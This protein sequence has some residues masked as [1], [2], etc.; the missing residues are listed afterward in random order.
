[1]RLR[2]GTTKLGL[3]LA[4]LGAVLLLAG[5]PQFGRLLPERPGIGLPAPRL[6][7]MAAPALMAA[8]AAG[9]A[10]LVVAA[11]PRRRRKREPEAVRVVEQPPTPWWAY[12]LAAVMV[13]GLFLG[14]Y[15]L[16]LRAPGVHHQPPALVSDGLTTPAAA[17]PAPT[18]A[19]THPSGQSA[20]GEGLLSGGLA[21]AVLW[22]AGAALAGAMALPAVARLRHRRGLPG[23]GEAVR[24]PVPRNE[25]ASQPQ[26]AGMDAAEFDRLVE[27]VAGTADPRDAVIRAY[28]VLEAALAALNYR[29]PPARTAAEHVAASVPPPLRGN[30]D[31]FRLVEL[32]HEA[33][34][35]QRPTT[36]V[37]RQEAVD[38]LRRL[39]DALREV[40]G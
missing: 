29:R 5:E 36:A 19:R 1:M 16:F 9:I 6:G 7:G 3:A 15:S 18:T 20:A 31:A 17:P 10:A 25:T 23:D 28:H 22:V 4:G 33:A 37:E 21:R 38:L 11:L 40:P 39:W 14:F 35:G 30:P 13:A 24:A 2:V 8:A 32:Y 34:Y 12:V 27:A 26:T